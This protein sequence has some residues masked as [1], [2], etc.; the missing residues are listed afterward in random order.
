M[1]LSHTASS[2]ALLAETNSASLVDTATDGCSLHLQE[3]APPFKKKVHA[4]IDLRVCLCA[5]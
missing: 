5:A 1:R 3:M 4:V 2:A